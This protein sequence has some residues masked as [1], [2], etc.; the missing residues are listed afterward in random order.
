MRCLRAAYVLKKEFKKY[1][2]LTVAFFLISIKLIIHCLYRHLTRKKTRDARCFQAFR[3]KGFP[4]PP[5]SKQK[6]TG[7]VSF[8][9]MFNPGTHASQ[10]GMYSCHMFTCCTIH[11]RWLLTRALNSFCVAFL[12]ASIHIDVYKEQL[13]VHPCFFS[14]HFV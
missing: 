13:R 10:L 2:G 14:V 9:T 7:V 6:H 3:Q 5:N 12:V 4:I 1:L 8:M 11:C